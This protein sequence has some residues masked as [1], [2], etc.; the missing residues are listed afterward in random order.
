MSISRVPPEKQNNI[1]IDY[2]TTTLSRHPTYHLSKNSVIKQHLIIKHN[3]TDQL[4]SSDVRKIITDNTI[5]I[6]IYIY[7]IIKNDYKSLK[8]YA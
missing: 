5:I 3:S 8:Q 4:T 7:K 1:Y 2:T 6:Y